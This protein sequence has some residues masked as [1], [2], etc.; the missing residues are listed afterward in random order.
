MSKRISDDDFEEWLSEWLA[1]EASDPYRYLEPD[2]NATDLA[3][4]ADR[5]NGP[6]ALAV[7][8][9]IVSNMP[10][11]DSQGIPGID[12]AVNAYI[13]AAVDEEIEAA[14]RNRTLLS[15]RRGSRSRRGNR[16]ASWKSE[17]Q[18]SFGLPLSANGQP[19]YNF[20]PAQEKRILEAVKHEYPWLTY[21]DVSG[22]T[23]FFSCEGDDIEL[24]FD[25]DADV[26]KELTLEQV[27]QEQ[28]GI[29]VTTRVQVYAR[30]L[31]LCVEVGALPPQSEELVVVRG[32]ASVSQLVAIA[33]WFAVNDNE[34]D[35][36][37]WLQ[38]LEDHDWDLSSRAK[39]TDAYARPLLEA[40][41]WDESIYELMETE[42]FA[43][44]DPI[45]QIGCGVGLFRIDGAVDIR[46][47]M[48]VFPEAFHEASNGTL[49]GF[50]F[51]MQPGFMV[52]PYYVPWTQEHARIVNAAMGDIAAPSK[53]KKNPSKPKPRRHSVSLGVETQPFGRIKPKPSR[54]TSRS[55]R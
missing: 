34:V 26:F 47:H 22:E 54:K 30:I 46:L 24:Y 52:S 25:G 35:N 19:L 29:E 28:M 11:P 27:Y 38:F 50:A 5:D 32:G 51:D 55:R 16:L 18:G 17:N 44:V 23:V 12:D 48:S 14:E 20:T 43:W 41:F 9:E 21:V 13:T 7:H 1:D 3:W 53:P 37:A 39:H 6:Q 31:Q 8:E 15:F 49:G 2:D 42:D 10:T 40:L 45:E 33:G 4:H 36:E